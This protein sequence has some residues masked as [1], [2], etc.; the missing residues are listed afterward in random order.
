M[1]KTP[2]TQK[3]EPWEERSE[4]ETEKGGLKYPGIKKVQAIGAGEGGAGLLKMYHWYGGSVLRWLGQWEK[5]K[6]RTTRER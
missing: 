5:K 6:N 2:L 3:L 1:V 4:A